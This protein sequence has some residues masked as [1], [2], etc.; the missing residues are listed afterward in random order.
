MCFPSLFVIVFIKTIYTEVVK[1]SDLNESD[2]YES[3]DNLSSSQFFDSLNIEDKTKDD[4]NVQ[5]SLSKTKSSPEKIKRR[6]SF[7]NKK[8]FLKN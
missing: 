2:L 5:I 3:S 6:F 7:S 8:Y 4:S 1:L